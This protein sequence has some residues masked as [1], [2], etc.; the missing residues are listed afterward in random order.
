MLVTTYGKVM[1]SSGMLEF[2]RSGD[3]LAMILGHEL[4]HITKGLSHAE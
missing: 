4:A 3:E 2:L 1:I